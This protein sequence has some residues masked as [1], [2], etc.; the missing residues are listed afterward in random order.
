METLRTLLLLLTFGAVTS[1]N[2]QQGT[3]AFDNA[4]GCP[5]SDT[6]KRKSQNDELF[7]NNS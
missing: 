1:V 3:L 7:H 5:Q 6:G 2:A 4:D